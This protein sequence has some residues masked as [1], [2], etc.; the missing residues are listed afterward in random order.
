VK[1][2]EMLPGSLKLAALMLATLWQAAVHAADAD[3][4]QTVAQQTTQ[5]WLGRTDADE[6][7]SLNDPSSGNELRG[8]YSSLPLGGGVSQMLW[9]ARAQYGF[10]GGG[11]VSWKSDNVEFAGGNPGLKVT[12]EGE[13]FM[14][15]VFMGG[16][17]AVK[18]TPWLRLYAAAGPAI[19]W[20]YLSGD[21]DVDEEGGVLASGPNG[22]LVV[23]LGK[24]SNDF[25]VAVYARAGLEFELNNGIT[26]GVSARY[27][28]HDFSFGGGRSLGL[29]KAQY[30]LTL[31]GRL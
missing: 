27:V 24:N 5:V 25:S 29:D 30:F 22:F 28:D 19:A 31:G 26:F 20:G 7:W 1:I 6:A 14:L 17:V 10:E 8:D 3:I 2:L 13:F 11:L 21:D 23:E 15:D 12:V 9:G 18:P 4:P 16:V